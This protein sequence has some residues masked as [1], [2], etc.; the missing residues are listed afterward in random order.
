MSAPAPV[1]PESAGARRLMALADQYLSALY[2][3]EVNQ[4]DSVETLRQPNVCFLGIE[5][6]K[7]LVACGASKL[8]DDGQLY[9]EIK[10][11]FVLP[12]HRGRGHA[13]NI[14]LALEA[15]LRRRNVAIARLEAGNR[16]PEA[17]GLYATL[18][19]RT[20]G[21]F[22]AYTANPYSVFM[23]KALQPLPP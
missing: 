16:Q 8:M 11:L 6:G 13:R 2:P 17:L 3:P 23:E 1:A 21:P 22:G 7:E 20:R 19:Y 12:E 5:D 18:G 10:R 4:L 14:M 9:G 15:E